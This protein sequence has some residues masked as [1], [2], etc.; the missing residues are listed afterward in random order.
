MEALAFG[1]LAAILQALGYL[2]YSFK[3]LREDIVPNPA[4]WIMFAYG[5][6]LLVVVEWDRGASFPLLILP[7]VCA[8]LSVGIAWYCLHKVRRAW[9][10]E[11]PLERFSFGLDVFL[12]LAYVATWALITQG[13]IGESDKDSAEILILIC[14][15]VGIFTAFFPLLR[16]VYNHPSTEHAAPWIFWTVAYAIL[17]VI[18]ITEEGG[19]NELLLYPLINAGIHGF[20]AIHTAYW[21]LRHNLTTI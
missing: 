13:F 8:L 7:I 3:V 9:W 19:A 18:T 11:H 1:F 12:T 16:Q 10:P 2:A 5:T 15:N 20:V 4:S 17:S 21:R 14:W 6:T